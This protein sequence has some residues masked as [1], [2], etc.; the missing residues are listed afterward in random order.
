MLID[1]NRINFRNEIIVIY[2]IKK[3][4]NS[5]YYR[6]SKYVI[7]IDIDDIISFKD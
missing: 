4:I 1:F 2:L 5:I 7:K 3:V 6:F